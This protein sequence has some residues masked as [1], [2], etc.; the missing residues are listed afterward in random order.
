MYFFPA[1]MYVA[2]IWTALIVINQL[3]FSS[4][5]CIPGD[6]K[7]LWNKKVELDVLVIYRHYTSNEAHKKEKNNISFGVLILL[8]EKE[9][10][11]LLHL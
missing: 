10:Y 8:L 6:I 9:V 4:L 3:I 7:H 11:Q 1:K 5:D 2:Q